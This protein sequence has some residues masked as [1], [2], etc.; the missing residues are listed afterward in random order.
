MAPLAARRHLE[1]QQ[2][3]G[4]EHD[5]GEHHPVGDQERDEPPHRRW[6][7]HSAPDAK[8]CKWK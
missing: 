1:H 4:V 6:L 3:H 7:Q 2:R 5:D 8:G